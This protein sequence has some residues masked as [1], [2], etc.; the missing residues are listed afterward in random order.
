MKVFSLQR[1]HPY[2]KGDFI[3]DLTISRFLWLRIGRLTQKSTGTRLTT[4]H[5]LTKRVSPGLWKRGFGYHWTKTL[6]TTK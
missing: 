4:W 6:G 3:F 1:R 5:V 2:E